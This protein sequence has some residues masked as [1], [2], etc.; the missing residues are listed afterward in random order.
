MNLFTVILAQ[1]FYTHRDNGITNIHAFDLKTI[2]DKVGQAD[3]T[4]FDVSAWVFD[5][6]TRITIHGIKNI[7][8]YR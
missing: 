5:L 7:F 2:F 6:A 8:N 3:H 4:S 1:Y